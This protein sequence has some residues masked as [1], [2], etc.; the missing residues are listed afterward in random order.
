MLS[1]DARVKI[2][3]KWP[4]GFYGIVKF[5]LQDEVEDGWR[6]KM[7]FSKPVKSF[8]VS[9]ASVETISEDKGMF[10]LKNK[11]WNSET[12]VGRLFRFRFLGKK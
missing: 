10:I 11:T 9:G 8:L 7:T 2:V 1:E 12:P 6:V 4:S 3:H 5:Q